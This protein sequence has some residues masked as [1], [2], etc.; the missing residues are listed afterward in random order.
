VGSLLSPT[1]VEI[2]PTQTENQHPTSVP[3]SFTGV[4]EET[5][6]QAVADAATQKQDLRN[7]LPITLTSFSISFDY[8]EDKFVVTLNAPKDQ[9]RTEFDKWKSNTYPGIETNQF[10]FQ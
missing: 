6:P 4:L 10:N 1:P 8:T 9:S 3:A 5:L 2:N 7:Q